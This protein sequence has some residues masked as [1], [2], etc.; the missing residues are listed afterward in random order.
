MNE[1]SRLAKITQLGR[2]LVLPRLYLV[3][4]IFFSFLI[5]YLALPPH[6]LP[7]GGD[8]II[9]PFNVA[10]L[11]RYLV[12]WNPWVDVGTNV[13]QVLAGPPLT[14]ASILAFLEAIGFDTVFSSW[15]YLCA[16]FAIG[17]CGTAY[18]LRTLIP[19]VGA[20]QIASVFAGTFFFL[21]PSQVVDTFKMPWLNLPERAFFPVFL[22]L[23]ISGH[24]KKSMK[25]SLPCTAVSFVLMARF[26]GSSA[27]YAIVAS[28]F[29]ILYVA[30]STALSAAKKR[31]LTFLVAYV[32]A[33]L[34]GAI[35]VNAYWL[36]PFLINLNSYQSTLSAFPANLQINNWAGI[37]NTVRLLNYWGFYN[38]YV[39]YSSVYVS[40]A[41]VLLSTIALPTVCFATLLF[42]RTR[43]VSIIAA[44]TAFCIFFA[45]GNN[46]LLGQVFTSLV[47]LSV[48]KVF[49]VSSTIIPF[50][51]L[52]YSLLFGT[53]YAEISAIA[54]RL[55]R[56]RKLALS[57]SAAISLA[58]ILILSSWPLVTGA[59]ATDYQ[60]PTSLGVNIP[61]QYNHLRQWLN[62]QNDSG[63]ILLAYNPMIYVSTNWGFQGAVQFYQNYF[64]NP[65]I[66]GVGTP[67]GQKAPIVTYAYQLE[68]FA[69]IDPINAI[70]LANA[71]RE[72]WTSYEGDSVSV[73][74]FGLN[75]TTAIRLN[76]TAAKSGTHQ[77]S[78][79]FLSSQDWSSFDA[80]SLWV[81]GTDTSTLNIGIMDRSNTVIWF[82][83]DEFASTTYDGWTQDILPL[84]LRTGSNFD[85]R[86]IVSI[87]AEFVTPSTPYSIEFSS[88]QIGSQT[89]E[90]ETWAKLLG[91]LNVEWV[92]QDTSLVVGSWP[93][94]RILQDT[95]DFSI[96]F[97]EAP[98][99]L[100]KN[101]LSTAILHTAE[102]LLGIASLS[103]ISYLLNSTGFS[104]SD[105][106]FVYNSTGSTFN[107]TAQI[108]AT[109]T[110]D[111][112][113]LIKATSTGPFALV[114]GEQFDPRWVL[115]DS[116]GTT[117]AHFVVNG[118]A[119]GWIIP[120][121][122][123]SN[124]E[125][126]YSLQTSYSIVFL[127]SMVGLGIA[128]AGTTIWALASARTRL[129]HPLRRAESE[130]N[131]RETGVSPVAS[132]R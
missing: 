29:V 130:T 40:N 44:I 61:V 87:W 67:Y 56:T 86:N 91:M 23:F 38:G 99:T 22:A 5:A 34:A 50:V 119:N 126:T 48:L 49:Y 81:T 15:L 25:Y 7:L 66:T 72:P 73:T 41:V 36:Y 76:V 46:D 112:R 102:H 33:I 104:P 24:Q 107:S 108:S 39:P 59:V 128:T 120:N 95:R 52:L 35:V 109:R 32:G 17:S 45:M 78:Y 54:S 83:A 106:A 37:F 27:Q 100:Y 122:G 114:L 123:E 125:L 9:P 62:V 57:A 94:Y 75:N 12:A 110:S 132:H 127:V 31:N 63:R 113:Y 71:T 103:D 111:D 80:M 117:Y 16:F 30:I 79:S 8:N 21:N 115:T 51:A 116:R 60:Q 105:T 92:L 6:F 70:S 124:L 77:A 121:Q 14:D 43:R 96:A 58:L 64:S 65:M 13:P 93:D 129:K 11:E 69:Q 89:Y 28:A 42:N 20:N 131:P 4:L 74:N 2:S 53:F 68:H 85:A 84:K 26:P 3:S 47:S 98:L 90:S 82:S 55:R 101:N 97:S 18:L 19:R 88:I 118:F 1:S 10:E